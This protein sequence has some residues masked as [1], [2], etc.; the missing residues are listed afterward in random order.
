[1]R[2]R[3]FSVSESRQD[4]YVSC[5]ESYLL[6]VI[7]AFEFFLGSWQ[8]IKRE[9]NLKF[10]FHCCADTQVTIQVSRRDIQ[11][12]PL[13]IRKHSKML[14]WLSW[15]NF[16][17]WVAVVTFSKWQLDFLFSFGAWWFHLIY[18]YLFFFLSWFFFLLMNGYLCI[19]SL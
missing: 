9:P 3:G 5:L 15:H 1:M 16:L 2:T 11:I 8:N 19:L 12:L 13:D 6:E 18:T 14:Q 17:S 4:R 10:I 7:W